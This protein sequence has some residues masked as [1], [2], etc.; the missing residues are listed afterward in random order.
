[1]KG[2]SDPHLAGSRTCRCSDRPLTVV[3]VECCSSNTEQ[4]LGLNL[5]ELPILEKKNAT[6]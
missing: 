3:L 2:H 5:L 1:M 4:R 6:E